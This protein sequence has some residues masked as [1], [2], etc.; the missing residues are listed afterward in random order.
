MPA[1]NNKPLFML[2]LSF[3]I[4]TV[5]IGT[6]NVYAQKRKAKKNQATEPKMEIVLAENQMSRYRILLPSS[7]TSM[8]QKAATVL[9]EYILEISGAA[10]PVISVDQHRSP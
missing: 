6:S 3:L 9:Q 1:L 7:A 8:E 5:V 2:M 10:L 4:T